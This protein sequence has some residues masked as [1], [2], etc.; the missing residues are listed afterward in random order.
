MTLSRMLHSIKI[1]LF[2]QFYRL[3]PTKFPLDI[4]GNSVSH[5]TL[6]GLTERHNDS[7][8]RGHSGNMYTDLS[9]IHS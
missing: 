3:P 7:E 1:R 6:G 5:L 2:E 4:F 9:S 8:F